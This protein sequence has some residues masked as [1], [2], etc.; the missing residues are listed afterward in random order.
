MDAA[1]DGLTTSL[2]ALAHELQHA[3]DHRG[4]CR[5]EIRADYE[6]S[7]KNAIEAGNKIR[8][9]LMDLMPGNF[10]IHGYGTRQKADYMRRDGWEIGKWRPPAPWEH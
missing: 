6:H 7:E 10:G 1:A 9:A 4:G 8:N 2:P 3:T 5:A